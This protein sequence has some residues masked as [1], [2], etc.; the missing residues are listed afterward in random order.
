M[1]Q[2]FFCINSVSLPSQCILFVTHQ[3]SSC[4]W[5]PTHRVCRTR[6]LRL[7][8]LV[9]SVSF[10]FC[11]LILFCSLAPVS[12]YT[13]LF[14]DLLIPLHSLRSSVVSRICFLPFGHSLVL[15]WIPRQTSP[16]SRR[17]EPPELE[18][19]RLSTAT[20]LR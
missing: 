5:D 7:V 8:F 19:Q 12:L 10:L 13:A 14:C 18:H 9:G 11:S 20:V 15:Q 3:L 17:R 16:S 4:A 2:T 6:R 1:E